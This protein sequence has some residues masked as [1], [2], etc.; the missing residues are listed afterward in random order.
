MFHAFLIKYGEI[1]IKGKNRY[2]FEDALVKQIRH[3]LKKV[4]GEFNVRKEQ[5]RIFVESEGLFDFEEVVEALQRVFGIVGICPV[6]KVNDEGFDQLS[7]EV[8]DYMARVYPDGA[9]VQSQCKKSK[10]K[11]SEKFH[12]IKC[13]SWR[14]YSGSVSEYER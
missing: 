8:I 11:L 13:R 2:L 5:G 14:S 4:E 9:Y 12:G 3:A 7:Q 10:K 6:L 1:G